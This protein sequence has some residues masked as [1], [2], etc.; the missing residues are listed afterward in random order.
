MW[1]C[2]LFVD[3][4]K[5][6]EI[7]KFYCEDMKIFFWLEGGWRREV[8]SAAR[9]G[10]DDGVR[11]EDEVGRKMDGLVVKKMGLFISFYLLL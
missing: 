1:L 11:E 8:M 10:G 4:N 5:M 2:G 6:G 9:S 7:T 3:L